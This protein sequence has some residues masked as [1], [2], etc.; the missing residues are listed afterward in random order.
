MGYATRDDLE[1]RYGSDEIADLL[2]DD[3]DDTPARLAAVLS[4]A[5]GE[6]DAALAREYTL[7]LAPGDYPSLKAIACALARLALYDDASKEA[8]TDA[9]QA[10]RRQLSR[11]AQGYLRNGDGAEPTR[12]NLGPAIKTPP[13]RIRGAIDRIN[14]R[15]GCS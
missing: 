6:I 15:E 4:D 9:A 13:A 7:P 3:A 12:R 2:C 11:L 14:R 10:A 8:V 5:A 1:A